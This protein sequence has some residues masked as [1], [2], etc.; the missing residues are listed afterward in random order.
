MARS[1]ICEL[2]DKP[3]S[4]TISAAPPAIINI[5]IIP[6]PIPINFLFDFLRGDADSISVSTCS[7]NFSSKL[8]SRLSELVFTPDCLSRYS[9]SYFSNSVSTLP[10]SFTLATFCVCCRGEPHSLQKLFPLGFAASHLIQILFSSRLA[11]FTLFCVEVL[12]VLGSNV[13]FVG[14]LILGNSTCFFLTGSIFLIDTLCLGVRYWATSASTYLLSCIEIKL[15]VSNDSMI[16][17]NLSG[18]PFPTSKSRNASS[19]VESDIYSSMHKML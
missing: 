12:S 10:I 15:L 2:E 19:I 13:G 8:G 6:I 11:V 4:P 18:L 7:T 5:A 14:F 16:C 1:S 3:M 17:F 9:R